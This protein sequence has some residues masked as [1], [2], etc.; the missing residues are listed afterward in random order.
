MQQRAAAALD[1]AQIVRDFVGAVDGKI[2]LRGLVQIG[3]RHAQPLGVAAGRFRCGHTDHVEASADPLGQKL[4]K[5]LGGRPAAQAKPHARTH[6]FEGAG[7][8]GTFLSID[9][10]RNRDN[11]LGIGARTASI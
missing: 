11:W 5:M 6:E 7:G 9:I 3:E 10:H 8:G 4:D 2:K 1:Q